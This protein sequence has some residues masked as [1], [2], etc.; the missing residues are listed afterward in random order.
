MIYR[1]DKLWIDGHTVP[2]TDRQ[3]QV[4]AILE[5]RNWPRVTTEYEGTLCFWAICTGSQSANGLDLS[6]YDL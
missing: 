3:N 4:T 1:A 5:A 2:H 6:R